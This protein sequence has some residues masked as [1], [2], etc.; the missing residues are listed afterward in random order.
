[1]GKRLIYRNTDSDRRVPLRIR[2]EPILQVPQGPLPQRG[3]RHEGNLAQLPRGVPILL[4]VEEGGHKLHRP[5][6]Q[7]AHPGS[8]IRGLR[9]GHAE[10]R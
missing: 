7:Q 1:M 4:K 10:A 3:V 8:L 9:G 2:L 5:L 6:P